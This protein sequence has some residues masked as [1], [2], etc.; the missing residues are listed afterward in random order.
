M[1]RE[2]AYGVPGPRPAHRLPRKAHQQQRCHRPH[3]TAL[4]RTQEW[5][6]CSRW[7]GC[8]RR[9]GRWPCGAASL[10]QAPGQRWRRCEQ[11]PTHAHRVLS[12]PGPAADPRTPAG[13]PLP[14]GTRQRALFLRAGWRGRKPLVHGAQSEQLL[15]PGLAVL[16]GDWA[17]QRGRASKPPSAAGA[18]RHTRCPA[19]AW[20]HGG[21][22]CFPPHSP[23]CAAAVSGALPPAAP[24]AWHLCLCAHAVPSCYLGKC[25][26]ALTQPPHLWSRLVCCDPPQGRPW[27]QQA[28]ASS[29][30]R[31]PARWGTLRTEGPARPGMLGSHAGPQEALLGWA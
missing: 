11:E 23:T 16:T 14:L 30:A 5:S 3:P 26:A 22:S 4:G 24:W 9:A 2:P 8:G 27:E 20:P 1:S 17:R 15:A 7:P 21:R 18:A 29:L 28:G 25:P 10:G 12:W 31:C 6:R 19:P 13:V